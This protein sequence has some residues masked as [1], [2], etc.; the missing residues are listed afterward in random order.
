MIIG[1]KIYG[2]TYKS[3]FP[4]LFVRTASLLASWFVLLRRGRVKLCKRLFAGGQL[5]EVLAWFI[6]IALWII[7]EQQELL[8]LYSQYYCFLL[9]LANLLELINCLF[10]N[11]LQTHTAFLCLFSQILNFN[12]WFLLRSQLLGGW[13]VIYN[14]T[15]CLDQWSELG[16]S[17]YKHS[18]SLVFLDLLGTY[19]IY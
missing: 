5:D 11:L 4:M 14:S 10:L 12:E 19:R 17:A 6:R 13:T 2:S 9:W 15:L 16:Q 8:F 7:L 18:Y 3:I 1:N